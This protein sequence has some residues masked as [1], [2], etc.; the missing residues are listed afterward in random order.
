MVARLGMPIVR[1]LELGTVGIA[2]PDKEGERG[3]NASPSAKQ[4]D[5]SCNDSVAMLQS[6]FDDMVPQVLTQAT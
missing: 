4:L 6:N 1:A 3:A 2:T 5:W